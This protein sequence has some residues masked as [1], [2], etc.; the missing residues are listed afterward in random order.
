MNR[1]NL[2]K[3]LEDRIVVIEKQ[4][5]RFDGKVYNATKVYKRLDTQAKKEDHRNREE[6]YSVITKAY[7]EAYN[8]AGWPEPPFYMYD[9]STWENYLKILSLSTKL[10][11]RRG[12]LMLIN[13]ALRQGLLEDVSQ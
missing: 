11:N 1:E 4:L 8:I 12:T 2:L 6:H 5:Q 7:E 9:H 10:L 13:C 3:Y